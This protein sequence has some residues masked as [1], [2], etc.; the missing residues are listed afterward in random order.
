[1]KK[2]LARWLGEPA[3]SFTP[4]FT[5]T[6]ASP[7]PTTHTKTINLKLLFVKMVL[8]QFSADRKWRRGRLLFE[9]IKCARASSPLRCVWNCVKGQSIVDATMCCGFCL[10]SADDLSLRQTEGKL[11]KARL[12]PQTCGPSALGRHWGDCWSTPTKRLFTRQLKKKEEIVIFSL[13]RRH[14]CQPRFLTS[15]PPS[16]HSGSSP[17]YHGSSP[18]PPPPPPSAAPQKQPTAHFSASHNNCQKQPHRSRFASI[19]LTSYSL[20]LLVTSEGG[21]GWGGLN[22]A[23]APMGR[24]RKLDPQ[25][26]GD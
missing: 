8:L 3:V 13:M 17:P 24:S 6:E 22:L 11:E 4:E 18:P 10:H 16:P 23:L 26:R 12:P 2:Q 9:G 7:P 5:E 20:K 15:H 14:Y 21:G 25:R 1:M 19:F